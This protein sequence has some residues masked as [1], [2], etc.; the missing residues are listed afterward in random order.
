DPFGWIKAPSSLPK[1]PGIYI[2][3]SEKLG[4]SYVGSS[5]N[6][7]ERV[8]GTTHI[9]AQTLL[10]QKDVIVEYVKVNLGTVMEVKDTKVRDRYINHILRHYE[11]IEYE[12]QL[13]AG[14]R[15]K[16]DPKKPPESKRKIERNRQEIKQFSASSEARERCIKRK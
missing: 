14:Y 10:A 7:F 15:M 3:T 13:Q 9:N 8:S 6:M 5:I 2:L 11:Q 4:E 1:S 12:K 16:N